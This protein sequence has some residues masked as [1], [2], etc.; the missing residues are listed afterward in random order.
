M[1]NIQNFLA[2][3][4]RSMVVSD[5]DN[6]SREFDL[7]NIPYVNY[8][9]SMHLNCFAWPG[10]LILVSRVRPCAVICYPPR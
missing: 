2:T 3:L 4:R 6:A 7:F 8:L 1:N 9:F 10:I 5:A